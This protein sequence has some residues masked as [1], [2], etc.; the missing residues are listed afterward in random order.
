MKS[1]WILH[2]WNDEECV[3]ILKKCKESLKKKGKVG[4]VIII[5]MVLDIDQKGD[6]TKSTETQLFF[7]M[8]M[9]VVVTGKERNEKE[10]SNLIY[11]AGFSGYKITPILGLRSV[12]EIY[13]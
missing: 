8:L 10:W 11:S 6:I 3:K 5:E 7:D 9:M 2:S 12:I 1:Q 4:K 13:P